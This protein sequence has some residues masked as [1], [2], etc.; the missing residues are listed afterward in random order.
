MKCSKCKEEFE[1]HELDCSHDIPKYMGGTD[2]DGR[3]WLCKKHHE[4]YENLILK[5][6]LEFVGEEFIQEERTSWMIELKKQPEEL[7]KKF[8]EF[9][10]EIRRWYYE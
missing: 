5:W 9:A 1:E 3:H 7:K 8:R 4:E 6:C 2:L 10:Q